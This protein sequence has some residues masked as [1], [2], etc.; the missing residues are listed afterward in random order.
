M[1]TCYSPVS[2]KYSSGI[3]VAV[4]KMLLRSGTQPAAAG[5]GGPGGPGGPAIPIGPGGPAM[6]AGP[7]GPTARNIQ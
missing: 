4:M 7:A 2:T 1:Y 5:A 3:P 6:P